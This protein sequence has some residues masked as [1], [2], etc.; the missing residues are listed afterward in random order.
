[1]RKSVD[2]FRKN[3]GLRPNVAK[4]RS[5]LVCGAQFDSVHAGHRVCEKCKRKQKRQ[6]ETESYEEVEGMN[7]GV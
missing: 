7:E 5:C 3:M 4:K 2:E 6:N 1:M